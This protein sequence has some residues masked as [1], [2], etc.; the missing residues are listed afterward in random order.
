MVQIRQKNGRFLKAISISKIG[1]KGQLFPQNEKN[2]EK[3]ATKIK[4]EKTK[5]NEILKKL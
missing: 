5:S 4:T 3:N 2:S 1:E